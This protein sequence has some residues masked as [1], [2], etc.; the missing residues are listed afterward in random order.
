MIPP[1][2]IGS[3]FSGIGG[4]ELGLEA[5]TNARTLWQVEKEPFCR[6]VLA[7]HYPEA[8]RYDDVCTVGAHNL[9]PVDVICGGFPCQ[10]LSY[11]G[12]GAGL[13]GER[14]GLWREY[15]RIVGELR[16]RYVFVE[17][18]S[19]LLARGL[20]TVLGDLSSLGYDAVWTTLRASDVGA[21]HR[22]ERLFI[23][24]Y[25]ASQG[26]QGAVRREPS[27]AP[28]CA[29][30]E[31]SVRREPAVVRESDGL[32]PLVDNARWPAGLGEPQ[33]EW[34]PPRV[35]GRFPAHSNRLKALGNAVV[36]QVAMLAWRVLFAHMIAAREGA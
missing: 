24:A 14:S 9:A 18:V 16:P 11:A 32:P 2:T 19:A 13:A 3:L 31:E 1:R 30:R 12:K 15:R 8:T 26:L 33:H 23:L 36:P 35:E 25:A 22:R 27:D 20:G 28:R 4:L 29:G 17:N 6:E 7:K 21:P 5:A 10:D 34:E